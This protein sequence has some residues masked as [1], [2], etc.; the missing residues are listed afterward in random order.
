[1]IDLLCCVTDVLLAVL[2]GVVDVA[3][4]VWDCRLHPDV[5]ADHPDEEP[6]TEK[7]DDYKGPSLQRGKDFKN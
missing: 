4:E 3:A 5:G 7:E 6:D 1:M 2:E